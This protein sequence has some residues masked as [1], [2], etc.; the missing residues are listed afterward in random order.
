MQD[1]FWHVDHHNRFNWD[2]VADE[3]GQQAQLATCTIN[4][5][6]A[7]SPALAQGSIKVCSPPLPLP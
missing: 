7:T 4:E 5:L 2:Y 6:R 3:I 1:G